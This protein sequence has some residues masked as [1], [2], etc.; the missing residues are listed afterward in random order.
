MIEPVT[1][2]KIYCS[3]TWDWD[4]SSK[5]NLLGLLRDVVETE[6]ECAVKHA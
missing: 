3:R 5:L 4:S 2:N 1:Q 6:L